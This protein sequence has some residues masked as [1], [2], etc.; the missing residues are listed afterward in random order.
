MTDHLTQVSVLFG[1]TSIQ[2]GQYLQQMY[3]NK[4]KSIVDSKHNFIL[5]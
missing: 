1:S 4:R 2:E 5:T 3:S